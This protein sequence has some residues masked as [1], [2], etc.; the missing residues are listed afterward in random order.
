MQGKVSVDWSDYSENGFSLPEEGIYTAEIESAEVRRGGSGNRYIGLRLRCAET[1]KFLAWD[2]LMID[3]RGKNIGLTKL[4]QLGIPK[5]EETVDPATL[6][7]QTVTVAIAH[8]TDNND[9]PKAV[10]DI[11]HE[12][13]RCGYRSTATAADEVA[14]DG[15]PF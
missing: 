5:D 13:F 9:K 2:N 10:V 11:R 6:V 14:P 12:G 3:G 4:M 7:G 15:T 8:G 1:G